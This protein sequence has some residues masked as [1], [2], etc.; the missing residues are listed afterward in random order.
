MKRK[1]SFKKKYSVKKKGSLFEDNFILGLFSFLF[2][3][4]FFFY[5]FSFYPLFQINSVNFLEAEEL[6]HLNE[7]AV[8]DLVKKGAVH[9]LFFLQSKSIFLFPEKIVEK[10]I[11]EKAP[12]VKDISLKRVFPDKIEV[13]MKERTPCAYWCSRKKEECYYLDSEGVIFEKIVNF[14]KNLPI[15]IKEKDEKDY[16]GKEVINKENLKKVFF[17]EEVFSKN[18][19]EI[20]YFRIFSLEKLEVFFKK[21]WRAYFTFL[22]AEKEWENLNLIRE[23]ITNEKWEDINYIDLRFEDRIFYK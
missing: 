6:N 9:N 13:K 5:L 12:I 4:F 21:G 2:L 15:I 1:K 14:E 19:E 3:S 11:L 18:E 7:D 20:V 10:L 17:L 22:Q 16:L 23:E 8:E